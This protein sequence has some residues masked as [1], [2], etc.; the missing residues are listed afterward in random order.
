MNRSILKLDYKEPVAEEKWVEPITF[1]D[2]EFWEVNR[3]YDD[4][5]VITAQIGKFTVERIMVDQGSSTD[6]LY[7]RC[8]DQLGIPMEDLKD[9]Y[10]NLI[11][12]TGDQIPAIGKIDLRLTVGD[13][14]RVNSNTVEFIV[15][16]APSAYNVLLGRPSLNK[17]RAVISTVHLRMKFPTPHGVG[18]VR[19]NQATA[20]QCYAVSLEATKEDERKRNVRTPKVDDSAEEEVD[21]E[22]LN[23]KVEDLRDEV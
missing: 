22:V 10:G 14:P 17:M 23:C 5:M 6:I 9:H 12:F 1:T 2:D 16:Q 21:P 7:K 15:V 8:F 4:P 11:G 13:H 18:Q 20:R 19:T 3:E